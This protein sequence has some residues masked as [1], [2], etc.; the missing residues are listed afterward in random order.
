MK[1]TVLDFRSYTE[2][3]K[4]TH[5]DKRYDKSD[6][7]V[8]WVHKEQAPALTREKEVEEVFLEMTFELNLGRWIVCL[9]LKYSSSA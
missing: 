3:G 6:V 9:L 2:R 4:H 1:D 5:C 8:L 7:G